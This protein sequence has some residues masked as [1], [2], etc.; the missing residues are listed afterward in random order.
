MNIYVQIVSFIVSFMFGVFYYVTSTI[1]ESIIKSKSM[2]LKIIITFLFISNNVI[3]YLIILYKLNYAEFHL[4]FMI[5]MLVGY[6]CG[7]KLRK[8]LVKQ[9]KR[10]AFL[11]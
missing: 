5:L 4:Y 3:I 7:Y 2:P 10:L 6:Y 11:K 9:K 1:N 8:L